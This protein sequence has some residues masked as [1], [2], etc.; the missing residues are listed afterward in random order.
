M[1]NNKGFSLLELIIVIAIM[2]VALFFGAVQADVIF[3]YSAKEARSKINTSLESLRVSCLSKSRSSATTVTDGTNPLD[4]YMELYQEGNGIYYVRYHEE[5]S[6]DVV[7]KLNPR[8]I[9]I[10]YQLR[11]GVLQDIGAKGHGLV[12]AYDRTTGGF[13]PQGTGTDDV[14]KNIVCSTGKKTYEL[15]LMPATGKVIM[16]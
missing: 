8:A 16:K 4:I 2:G 7:S 6:D 10:K 14:V 9:S 5:G 12:M 13:I 3:G 15:E 11:G 1:K